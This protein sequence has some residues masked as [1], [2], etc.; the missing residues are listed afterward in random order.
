MYRLVLRTFRRIVISQKNKDIWSEY[1]QQ[2][3]RKPSIKVNVRDQGEA[4]RILQQTK[5]YALLIRNV[6]ER[7]DLLHSYN[8]GIPID[9][10]ER[11]MNRKAAKYVG[12]IMPQTYQRPL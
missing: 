7:R 12:F 2:E 10:R 8:I 4:E 5:E 3:F 6:R 9:Q 11:E 1:I